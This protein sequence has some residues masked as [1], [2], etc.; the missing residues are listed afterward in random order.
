MTL[1]FSLG[2]KQSWGT[3]SSMQSPGF[4]WINIDR[5]ID[6]KRFCRQIITALPAT[7]RAALICQGEKPELLLEDLTPVSV[8]KLPLFTL[9]EKKMALLYLTTDLARSLNTTKRLFILLTNSIFWQTFTKEEIQRW[10]QETNKWLNREQSTL[11]ILNHGPNAAQLKNQLLSQHRFL[12]GL[13]RVHWQQDNLQYIISWWATENGLTAN[14]T[15]TIHN[16]GL[17]WTIQPNSQAESTLLS[18][19]EMLYLVDKKIL[20]GTF[21]PTENWQLLDNNQL[22]AQKAKQAQAATLIFSLNDSN[23]INELARQIHYLRRQ[24]GHALKIVIREMSNSI[25][26][27]DERLLLACGANLSVPQTVSLPKFL[28]MVE[29]IQG[30]RF[31]RYVP[32]DFNSLL[33]MI[34]P[35]ELKGY[36]PVKEFTEAV[37]FRMNNTLLPDNGKGILVA[38]MPESGVDARQALSLCELKRLGDIA[39][40][41]DNRLFL[42]L[43][44]CA[45]SDLDPTLNFIF[46]K[47]VNMIFSSHVA[48]DLDLQIITEMKQLSLHHDK[49]LNEAIIPANAPKQAPPTAIARRTPECI[50]LSTNIEQGK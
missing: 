33:T 28:T 25:R 39:T 27:S 9:P 30:Q 35:I 34:Q 23:Q 3:L 7:A 49:L 13:S 50:T 32:E 40:I 16:E 46:H 38:L 43:S 1:S 31:T 18:N 11:L 2:M 44:T 41:S 26:Y 10:V 29:S 17:D 6:A 4:Y 36:L 12:N 20:E 21:P 47:P 14:Q 42:F 22:L 15:F 48:W 45:A 19:D 24:C 37:L 5:P 8:K